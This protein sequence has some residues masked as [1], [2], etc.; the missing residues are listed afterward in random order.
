[1]ADDAVSPEGKT[2]ESPTG[3]TW[4]AAWSSVTPELATLVVGVAAATALTVLVGWLGARA[5]Q[6]HDVEA[7]RDRLVAVARQEAVNIT[8]IDYQHAE[9]DVQQV[10][11]LATGSFYASFSRSAPELI[12]TVKQ[13]QSKAVG[14][15]T[16]AGLASE[17]GNQAQVLVAVSVRSN[18]LG[19]LDKPPRQL[20]MRVMLQETHN[21]VKVADVEIVQ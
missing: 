13:E 16:A 3:R 9:A 7:Q 19:G 15:A 17:A 5:Y 21:Q 12:D 4:S 18:H 1:M 14:T 20:R 6:A 11:D 2:S 8:T 10:L